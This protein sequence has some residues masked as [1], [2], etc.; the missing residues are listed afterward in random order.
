MSLA[1]ACRAEAFSEGGC[2]LI[3]TWRDMESAKKTNMKTRRDF[4][5]NILRTGSLAAMGGLVDI[6]LSREACGSSSASQTELSS[7]ALI[8]PKLIRHEEI[9]E[10]LPAGLTESR[11]LTVDASGI[12]YV[13]GDQAIKVIDPRGLIKET[14]TLTVAPRCLVLSHEQLYIGT[15]DRVIIADRKGGVQA[16]WP[17]LGDNAFI[18]SIALDEEHVYI[19]DAG[20]RI[21]WCFD[22]KGLFIRRIGDKDPD[23]NIPGFEVPSPYFDLAVGPDGLLW[24]ANPGRHQVEAYTAKGDREFAWGRF[25]NNLEDF[26]GC[27]NPVNFAIL[28]DGS[29]VTCEKGAVRVKVYNAGGVLMGVVTGL[30]QLTG[31]SRSISQTQ[32]QHQQV[33]LDVAVDV[34]GHIYILDR[35]RNVI[36]IFRHKE[37]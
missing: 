22:R 31:G 18:T 2:A 13:A 30:Q 27:C 32:E 25:G 12:L 33:I 4:L 1:P 21:V 28:G 16:T 5:G 8:D 9:G 15:R 11:A 37:V 20:Q 24:V 6:G 17:S 7:I 34:A 14:L 23:R 35:A 29:F 36:R 26:T 3:F 19:A 10:P